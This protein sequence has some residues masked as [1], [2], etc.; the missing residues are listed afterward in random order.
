MTATTAFRHA[1]AGFAGIAIGIAAADPAS[2][3]PAAL[4][5][6]LA[7]LTAAAAWWEG[8]PLRR[9]QADLDRFTE[10]AIDPHDPACQVEDLDMGLA[11]ARLPDGSCNLA[12]LTQA[13]AARRETTR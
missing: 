9:Y 2:W 7:A 12:D 5:A 11:C 13:C 3:I 8:E 4:F 6:G 1:P 10:V